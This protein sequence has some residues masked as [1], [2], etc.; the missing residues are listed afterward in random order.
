MKKV[1]PFLAIAF[2]VIGAA[3]RFAPH[4]PNFAPI[5]AMALFGG[6]YLNKKYA[7]IVPIVAIFVSDLFIGF[8]D[9]KLMAGVYLSFILVGLI[10][11]FIKK[12]KNIGT[13]IGGTVLGSVLFFLITNFAVWA[14]YS[15][16]PHTLNGLSQ[17]FT[18]ALPFFR[19]TLIGDLFY[20]AILFGVYEVVIASVR[21]KHLLVD[22]NIN[23]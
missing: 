18:M 15:W 4:F 22:S 20:V 12:H 1:I 8:Y 17:C 19:G 14:F 23:L 10:G 21:K 16:Y 3:L 11:L 13:I 5:A 6:V 7:L 9:A 2:V